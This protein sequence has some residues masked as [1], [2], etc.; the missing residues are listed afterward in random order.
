MSTQTDASNMPSG[1]LV[2]RPLLNPSSGIVDGGDSQD[3][4]PYSGT[5]RSDSPENDVKIEDVQFS[6][7][8]SHDIARRQ[9]EEA[10]PDEVNGVSARGNN[11]ASDLS[12][13][14]V[15]APS[16]KTSP[17]Y[18]P[19]TPESKIFPP[20]SSPASSRYSSPDS[21][22]MDSCDAILTLQRLQNCN[23]FES[24]ALWLT[25]AR[26]TEIINHIE[27]I[28][29]TTGRLLRVQ[30]MDSQGII[31]SLPGYI[32]PQLRSQLDHLEERFERDMTF[33]ESFLNWLQEKADEALSTMDDIDN[34]FNLPYPER[35]VILLIARI[36]NLFAFSRMV[37]T[38]DYSSVQ[39]YFLEGAAI[40]EKAWVCIVMRQNHEISA[41][42]EENASMKAEIED[43][44]TPAAPAKTPRGQELPFNTYWICKLAKKDGTICNHPNREFYLNSLG[45]WTARTRCSQCQCKALPEN[46]QVI[47]QATFLSLQ[48]TPTTPSPHKGNTTSESQSTSA[49]TIRLGQ[50]ATIPD[51]YSPIQLRQPPTTR[52]ARRNSELPVRTASAG[53][54]SFPDAPRQSSQKSDVATSSAAVGRMQLG[55]AVSS[56]SSRGLAHPS[57]HTQIKNAHTRIRPVQSS[58]EQLEP[59]NKRK[60]YGNLPVS[61]DSGEMAR[62]SPK[63]L[64][65]H[66]VGQGHQ[67][68]LQAQY[69]ST[70]A[71]PVNSDVDA[72]F[73][74]EFDET[75]GS[76]QL[77]FDINLDADL[78]AA[79]D[80]EFGHL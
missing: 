26:T 17:L 15:T 6:R 2:H 11:S 70:A 19:R 60:A 51:E 77:N 43:F 20:L 73:E 9:L 5:P 41:L 8:H 1:G 24:L 61:N 50:L 56:Q 64:H 55:M 7:E 27:D 45:N 42:K 76:S 38:G 57:G 32:D 3:D 25:V 78:E 22:S 16:E 69:V 36:K 72:L 53:S 10:G 29:D 40:K 12:D 21:R 46:R 68:Q 14:K 37:E 23:D 34:M 49:S 18:L 4:N 28:I 44:K 47:D 30:A 63:R 39:K 74:E 80:A 33:R 71:N 59:T 48:R 35:P 67:Q 62:D 79:M 58:N 75:P 52:R 65:I 66:S 13:S 54:L 31:R